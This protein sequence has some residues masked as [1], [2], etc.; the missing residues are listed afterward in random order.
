MP[1]PQPTVTTLYR[2]PVK[3]MTPEQLPSLRLT[4]DGRVEGDR[5][6]GFRFGDAGD[7]LDWSWQNKRNF[8]G[9][10]NTPGLAKL[11]V[12]FAGAARRLR[13][14]AGGLLIAE[15][16][17]DGDAARADIAR[18]LA[19]YI[20]T[21]EVNPLAGFPERQPIV[22]V[23]D[24]VQPLFH[25]TA[26]GLVTMY[27]AESL[28][29]LGEKLGDP[30]IDGRRFRANV[31]IG[32]CSEPFEELSWAGRRIRIGQTV[33]T[34]TKPVTRCLVTHANPVTGSRDR[35]VLNALTRHFTPENPQFAVTLRA[36]S[37]SGLINSGDSVELI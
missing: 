14:H 19:D 5:V 31:V 33:F 8:V 2:H 27:S 4:P 18:L 1:M 22:L 17:I 10:V 3:S 30:G 6:L 7:A 32:G 28:N 11:N 35:D 29:A 23:G 34:V 36:V 9:L 12:E 25:D 24:G 13:I 26:E 15:G 21:L 37:G 16:P 20:L